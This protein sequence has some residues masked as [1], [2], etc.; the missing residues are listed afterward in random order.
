MLFFIPRSMF[1]LL[2]QRFFPAP[3]SFFLGSSNEGAENV[4]TNGRYFVAAVLLPTS[5]Q[6][7]LGNS[8]YPFSVPPRFITFYINE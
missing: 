5:L 2:T 8:Q 6:G 4:L 7:T 1:F 3:H